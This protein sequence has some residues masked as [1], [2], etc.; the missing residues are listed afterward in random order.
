[1]SK[2]KS[3]GKIFAR[4]IQSLE[5]KKKKEI[6][7]IRKEIKKAKIKIIMN[8]GIEKKNIFIEKAE[9]PKPKRNIFFEK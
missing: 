4:A 1:M 2:K 5:K 8:K 3:I 6:K 9:L 7:R